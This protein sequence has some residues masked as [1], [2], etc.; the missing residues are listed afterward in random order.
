MVTRGSTVELQIFLEFDELILMTCNFD[1][2]N[3]YFDVKVD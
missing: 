1:A 2:I 3:R